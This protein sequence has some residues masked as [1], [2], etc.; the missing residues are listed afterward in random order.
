[1]KTEPRPAGRRRHVPVG[2]LIVIWSMAI[3]EPAWA[4]VDGTPDAAGMPGA[5]L[6]GQIINW[7][8]WVSLMASLGAV[9]YGAAMWRGGAG[10]IT[11]SRVSERQPP[12]A[13]ATARMKKTQHFIADRPVRR[14]P[15]TGVQAQAGESRSWDTLRID[16]AWSTQLSLLRSGQARR[17]NDPHR[18]R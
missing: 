5:A 8:M 17:S 14:R 3:S 4:Q 12:W 13:V 16:A 11:G 7:L 10:P 6:I 15:S 1:M 2:S 9:L 18:G